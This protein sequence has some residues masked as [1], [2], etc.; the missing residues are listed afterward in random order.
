MLFYRCLL[1][2][3]SISASRLAGII[4]ALFIP[5]P[6]GTILCGGGF[7]VPHAGLLPPG[8]SEFATFIP[9]LPP[10]RSAA[11]AQQLRTGGRV[12]CRRLCRQHAKVKLDKANQLVPADVIRYKNLIQRCSWAYHAGRQNGHRQFRSY[13]T[14]QNA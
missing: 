11:T 5:V 8:V 10:L 2:C 1:F 6:I 9:T 7:L 13:G 12:A 14:R 3:S 4:G